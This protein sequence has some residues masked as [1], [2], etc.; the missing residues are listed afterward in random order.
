MDRRE[1][2]ADEV[3]LDASR[4]W[5][6]GLVIAELVRNAARHGLADGASAI[7]VVVEDLAGRVRCS[8]CDDGAGAPHARPGRG[9][10]LVQAFAAD[11][12]GAVTWSFAPNGCWA[13]LEFDAARETRQLEGAAGFP[14][15]RSALRFR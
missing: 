7:W 12:G 6:V 3:W 4:C 1:G 8:V 13:V 11:L 10:R 9:R 5:R 15:S 14:N 2:T